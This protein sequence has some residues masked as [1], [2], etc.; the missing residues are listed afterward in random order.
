MSVAK[1]TLTGTTVSKKS[2]A[3]R[4][5]ASRIR[6]RVHSRE[7]GFDRNQDM[8]RGVG[9][10]RERE[11]EELKGKFV[12]E[13]RYKGREEEV[14]ARIVNKQRAQYGETQGEK[15]KDRQGKSPDRDLPLPRYQH[16]TIAQIESEIGSLPGEQIRQIKNYEQSHKQ[17]KTLIEKLDRC[18]DEKG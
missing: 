16:K 2:T 18:I 7:A 1:T 15:Q 14:A 11:Y 10:K 6:F 4:L 8:P 13:G 12:E 5:V 3:L 17:R 9:P